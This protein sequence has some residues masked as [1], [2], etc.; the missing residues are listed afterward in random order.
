FIL[1]WGIYTFLQL[2]IFDAFNPISVALSDF[3]MTDIAFSKMRGRD[4][5]PSDTNVVVVNIS[6]PYII[7]R[8]DFAQQVRIINK[9][10]P[11]VI[12]VD[13]FYDVPKSDT[14][15][16]LLLADA[17]SEV[18]NLVMVTSLIYNESNETYDSLRRSWEPFRAN[19]H[20]GFANLD[21]DANVQQ[22]FKACRQFPPTKMVNGEKQLAFSVKV[23]ELFN[24][25]AAKRFLDRNNE[26]ETINYSGNIVDL[27]NASDFSGKFTFL[28][29]D[30]V[31][32]ENFE[33]S[34]IKD[35]IVLFGFAGE[36]IFDTSWD[37]KFFTPLNRHYAGK[38]N[39]DMY[40]VV[41]HAN[42]ISMI[43]QDAPIDSL[44]IFW[45]IVLGVLLCFLN[46]VLF[47]IIYHKLPKWYDGLTKLIQ[48]AEVLVLVFII[49][50]VF[51]NSSF[52]LN[53]TIGL[54]AVALAGDSLEVYYGVVDNLIVRIRAWVLDF[55]GKASQENVESS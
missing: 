3:E 6:A 45:D 51:A 16:D 11:K 47:S 20:E 49:I 18:K 50:L 12:G 53:L 35:K 30:T 39:P 40:G 48:L 31:L 27:H 2:P 15:G 54:A 28:D 34:L 25:A 24:P 10:D 33:P 44:S 37:D 38:T 13:S 46:V 17:L 22:D 19:A 52:S 8:S 43:L 42:I 5:V 1:M 36:N 4:D 55:L 21:T 41:V 29:W 7:K 32:D 26:W 14:L 23:A 9:Y